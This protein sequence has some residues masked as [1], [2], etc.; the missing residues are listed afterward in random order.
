PKPIAEYMRENGI[1]FNEMANNTVFCLHG[2]KSKNA[3]SKLLSM[4]RKD[5]V[6]WW[7]ERYGDSLKAFQ[8]FILP[9]RTGA[10]YKADNWL[11]LGATTGGK[12]LKTRT[13]PRAEYEANPEKYPNVE[14]RT[15]KGGEVRYPVREFTVTEPK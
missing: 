6:M 4:V 3:G 2:H 8:T 12:T 9:P 7:N 15:F 14:K 10:V 13:I 11:K 1:A 5:E